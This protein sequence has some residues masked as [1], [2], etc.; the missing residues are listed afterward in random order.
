MDFSDWGDDSRPIRS[1]SR[2]RRC[3]ILCKDISA[4]STNEY[5]VK[6]IVKFGLAALAMGASFGVG[7]PAKADQ[8]V[9][10]RAQQLDFW[11]VRGLMPPGAYFHND[12]QKPATIAV[13]KFGQGIGE[14]QQTI[15]K[16]GKKNAHQATDSKKG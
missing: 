7:F 1:H 5:E 16:L 2:S 13:N 10:A 8:L 12:N 11:R 14:Q 4:P 15:S 6:T 3:L 9:W